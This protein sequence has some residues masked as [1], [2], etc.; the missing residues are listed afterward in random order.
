MIAPIS[1]PLDL[2][3]YPIRIIYLPKKVKYYQLKWRS[4]IW[5]C[6]MEKMKINRCLRWRI[7]GFQKLLKN[8]W[9]V[10]ICL[11]FNFKS[12]KNHQEENTSFL[13]WMLRAR[14]CSSKSKLWCVI[15]GV[16]QPW[17]WTSC[18][19]TSFGSLLYLR[20]LFCK[21]RMAKEQSLAKSF[22]RCK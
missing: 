21:M 19:P 1:R 17:I 15:L 4:N 8:L 18:P 13:H 2:T 3:T 20:F 22:V 5:K 6:F 12:W 11:K 14:L 16:S 7:F 9:S 10:K